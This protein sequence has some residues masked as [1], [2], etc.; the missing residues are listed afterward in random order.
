MKWQLDP[1]KYFHT[2]IEDCKAAIVVTGAF[3]RSG[4]SQSL[5]KS[6]ITD[7]IRDHKMPVFIAHL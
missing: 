6:F 5:K 7:V 2:W 1:K 3:G 4:L